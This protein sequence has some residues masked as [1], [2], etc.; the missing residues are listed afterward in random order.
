VALAGTAIPNRAEARIREPTA[1]KG[2]YKVA[3]VVANL[4]NC[5]TFD[6]AK[7]DWLNG[8]SIEM[9]WE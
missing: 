7:Q 2:M 9:T 8:E 6:N 4:G 5:P 1:M 3:P